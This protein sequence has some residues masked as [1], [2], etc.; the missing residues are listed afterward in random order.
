MFDLADGYRWGRLVFPGLLL[1]AQAHIVH[2]YWFAGWFAPGDIGAVG[3]LCGLPAVPEFGGKISEIVCEVC[4]ARYEE[5]V[6]RLVM[7]RMSDCEAKYQRYLSERVMDRM[8]G[9]LVHHALEVGAADVQRLHQTAWVP[10][11]E[12]DCPYMEREQVDGGVTLR[13]LRQSLPERE[14]MG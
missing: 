8:V 3:T 13:K 5:E 11:Q 12:V 4:L 9:H 10:C 2:D 14:A 6:V 1:P 7:D